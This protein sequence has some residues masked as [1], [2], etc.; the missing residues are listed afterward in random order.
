MENQEVQSTLTTIKSD[1][2]E[3]KDEIQ[4]I[5]VSND[6]QM[7]LASE[8]LSKVKTR[9]NRVEAKRKKYVGPLNAQVKKINADFK[10]VKSPYEEMERIVKGRIGAYVTQ[11][12][13]EQEEK[14]R[15]EKRRQQEEARKL[16]EKEKIS[17]Q[18]A[19]A[20]LRKEREEQ[21][22]LK[23]K[24]AEIAPKTSS[25]T[26]KGKVVT[27]VVTKFEVTDPSKVPDMYKVVDEKLIRQAV[28]NGTKRI[29]GVRIYEDTQV[30]AR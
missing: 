24:D 6:E 9:I 20:Q 29:A 5:I 19:A 12:R 11:K 7:D 21:N 22:A 18:K 27:K 15:E 10:A 4:K 25:T 3:I 8:F 30:C 1:V 13:K 23:P 14:E 28:N 26:E 17:N 2:V 16:A